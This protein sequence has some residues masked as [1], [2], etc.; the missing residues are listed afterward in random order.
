V[1]DLQ[2]EASE[3]EQPTLEDQRSSHKADL[4]SI[5]TA[6]GVAF[7]I[8][9]RIIDAMDDDRVRLY[10]LHFMVRMLAKWARSIG[11][12]ALQVEQLYYDTA[13]MMHS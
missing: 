13:S 10:V 2:G 3:T 8:G 1:S 4:W 11:E 12:A 7:Y 5:V 6:F 9:W